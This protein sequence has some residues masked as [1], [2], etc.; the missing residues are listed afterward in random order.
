[1]NHQ[2]SELYFLFILL[3]SIS[4]LT[5][6]IFK[7]F[8]YALILAIVFSTIFGPVHKR[9]LT[10]T[11]EKKGLSALLSTSFIFIVVLI[12]ISFLVVQILKEATSLYSLFTQNSSVADFSK[13][14][15][16]LIDYVK[17]FIPVPIDIS[18]DMEG[19]LK[20]A[21]SWLIQNIGSIF[22]NIA[23]V[24]LSV[25][26]FLIA[27]FVFFKDGEKLKSMII[28]LSPLRDV[29]DQTIFTKIEVAINSVMKGSLFVAIIQGVL[30][31]I[32]L[33]ILGVPNPILLGSIAIITALIPGIGTSIILLPAILYL[34][35]TGEAFSAVGLLIWGMLAVGLV[36]NF[37]G[38]RL[39][40]RGTKL[41][42][43]MILLSILGGLSFFGPIGFLLGPLVLSFL[44]VLI[45]VYFS[46]NKE[47]KC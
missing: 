47:Y 33:T 44:F 29:H 35:F 8:L 22:S 14:I 31:S 18:I 45:E 26:V 10:L 6:F 27:V 40:G 13:F 38:P 30:T 42:P 15:L 20:E 11:S 43:F 37:L 3:V 12:P 4:I 5:F 39:V 23:K 41:H 7:P 19:Y 9:I 34:F 2:K 21:L 28:S 24:L 32:G 25:F 17:N 36:D 46:I 16:N 1:M